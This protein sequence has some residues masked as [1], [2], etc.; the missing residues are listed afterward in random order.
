MEG[1]KYS[2]FIKTCFYGLFYKSC[3]EMYTSCSGIRQ[4]FRAVYPHEVNLKFDKAIAI[5]TKSINSFKKLLRSS[6]MKSIATFKMHSQFR[7]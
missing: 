5:T 6:S 2:N 7:R 3:N 1:W 4:T